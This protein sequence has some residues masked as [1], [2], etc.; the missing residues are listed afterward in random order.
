MYSRIRVKYKHKL[1]GK[2]LNDRQKLK[3]KENYWSK[4]KYFFKDK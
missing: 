1:I 4:N 2:T 3:A